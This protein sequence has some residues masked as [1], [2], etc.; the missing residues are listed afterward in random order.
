MS[1][2]T[3]PRF[4]RIL[5]DVTTVG[6]VL[7]F[8]A[9]V[10]LRIGEVIAGWSW[11]RGARSEP[12]IPEGLQPD[13]SPQT[14]LVFVGLI[15]LVLLGAFV[16]FFAYGLWK[17]I[18]L[19]WWHNVPTSPPAQWGLITCLKIALALVTGLWIMGRVVSFMDTARPMEYAL[20]GMF[21]VYAVTVGYAGLLLGADGVTRRDLGL[22]L[23]RMGTRFVQAVLGWLSFLPVMVIV[24]IVVLILLFIFSA[25]FPGI[26]FGPGPQN[27][28][29]LLILADRVSVGM[30]LYL[31][32]YAIVGAPIL[33]EIVFRG[34]CYG[35]FRRHMGWPAAAVI[36]GILFGL[37]HL[38]VMKFLPLTLLG[39]FLAVLRERSR[40][41]LLPILVHGVNNLFAVGVMIYYISL[42]SD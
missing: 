6:F 33:E 13:F 11:T 4:L 10:V 22:T 23:D 12:F 34:I 39:I 42:F 7:L 24:A 32:A 41:L 26:D 38:D 31:A 29:I 35:A 8:L 3:G 18:D 25:L 37:I 21:L 5:A 2:R 1:H 16:T 20:V 19:R 9:I 28:L 27:N 17:L 30:Q 15:A 40:G 36:S 14:A